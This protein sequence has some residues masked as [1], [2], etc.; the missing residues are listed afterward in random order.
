MVRSTGIQN[1]KNKKEI[2]NTFGNSCVLSYEVFPPN[3]NNLHERQFSVNST[4]GNK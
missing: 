2:N 4:S 3:K 1:K